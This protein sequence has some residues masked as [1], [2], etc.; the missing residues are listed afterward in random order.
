[1]EYTDQEQVIHEDDG[2]GGWVDTHPSL[3][4]AE[5]PA[6]AEMSNDD[7]VN[8]FFHSVMILRF[9]GRPLTFIFIV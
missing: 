1:M 8:L 4:G 5:L 3:E 9:P 6:S 7:K 2:E